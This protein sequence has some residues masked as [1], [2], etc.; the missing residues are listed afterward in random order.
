MR[1][2]RAFR[3]DG[4]IPHANLFAASYLYWRTY[5]PVATVP[6]RGIEGA[7]RDAG[8][9][10]QPARRAVAPTPAPRPAVALNT[11]VRAV[12]NDLGL[13]KTPPNVS[14]PGSTVITID[15]SEKGGINFVNVG[16]RRRYSLLY[17]S[18]YGVHPIAVAKIKEKDKSLN[19]MPL[20]C[21]LAQCQYGPL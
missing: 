5:L 20:K 17:H 3:R 13:E 16:L 1:G 7:R 8:G 6:L 10:A 15:G 2:V 4:R 21:L 19:H 11:V 9:A 14:M 12:Y 18:Q